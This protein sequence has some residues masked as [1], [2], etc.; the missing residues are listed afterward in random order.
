M[1][2]KETLLMPKTAVRDARQAAD[3]GTRSY[4]E[5]AAGWN[6]TCTRRCWRSREGLRSRSCCMTGRRMPTGTSNLGH[7]LNKIFK[8]VIVRSHYHGRVLGTPD[9]PGL[10]HARPADRDGD[11]EAGLRPQEDGAVAEFR[12]LCY[13]YALE[14]GGTARRAGFLAL[15]VRR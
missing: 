3:E 10:G 12:A 15:G 7:A 9:I 8:D 14:A 6:R 1:D 4:P 11:H 13:D 5:A 2:Y